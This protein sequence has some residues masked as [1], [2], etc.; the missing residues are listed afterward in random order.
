MDLNGLNT[1]LSLFNHSIH[2]KVS[3][4]PIYLSYFVFK[5]KL[6][7]NAPIFYFQVEARAENQQN[8]SGFGGYL[9]NQTSD[10]N[11]NPQ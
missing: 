9:L 3:I 4:E 10:V 2:I 6:R 11:Y 8:K 7:G 5:K 1:I